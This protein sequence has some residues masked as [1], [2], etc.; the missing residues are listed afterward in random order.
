[1][2]VGRAVGQRAHCNHIAGSRAVGKSLAVNVRYGRIRPAVR[3]ANF[4]LAVRWMQLEKVSGSFRSGVPYKLNPFGALHMYINNFSN[5]FFRCLR[6]TTILFVR[7][8][9]PSTALDWF[10]LGTFAKNLNNATDQTFT[11]AAC[12]FVDKLGADS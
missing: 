9:A 6:N 2:F 4:Q 8:S 1:M 7:G 10:L 12:R 5:Q 11:T 3:R